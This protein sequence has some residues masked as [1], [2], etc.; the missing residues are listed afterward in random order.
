MNWGCL[1]NWSVRQ[2]TRRSCTEEIH[3]LNRSFYTNDENIPEENMKN[4]WEE[5][6]N[7]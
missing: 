6:T 4:N 3:I 1:Q 2:H 5:I 7:A